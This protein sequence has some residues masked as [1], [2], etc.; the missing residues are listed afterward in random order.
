MQSSQTCNGWGVLQS[1][2]VTSDQMFRK[3]SQK[4]FNCLE[5]PI[6]SLVGDNISSAFISLAFCPELNGPGNDCATKTQA[7][8]LKRKAR[9]KEGTPYHCHACGA[10]FFKLQALEGHMNKHKR[11]SEYFV[12]LHVTLSLTCPRSKQF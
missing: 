10:G 2:Q 5:Q 4:C 12:L 1:L 9:H 3:S 8:G 11:P 7:S 6:L